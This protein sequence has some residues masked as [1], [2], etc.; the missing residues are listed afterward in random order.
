MPSGITVGGVF[1][2]VYQILGMEQVLISSSSYFVDAS[3]LQVNL[4]RSGN[5]LSS[6][7]F[8]EESLIRIVLV[9]VF[10]FSWQSA[11]WRDTVLKTKE[12]PTSSSYLN[13]RLSNVDVQNFSHWFFLTLFKLK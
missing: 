4:Q 12:F 6:T 2:S 11:I 7:R 5:V 1:F 8:L 9:H 3:R 10:V 13:S